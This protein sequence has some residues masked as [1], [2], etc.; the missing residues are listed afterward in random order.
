MFTLCHVLAYAVH[1][2]AKFQ[3]HVQHVQE[4]LVIKQ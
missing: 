1:G 2:T 4:L 3:A